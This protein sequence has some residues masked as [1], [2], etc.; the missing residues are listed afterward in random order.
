[1]ESK[2]ARRVWAKIVDDLNARFE[3][4]RTVDKCMHKIKYLIDKYKEKKD[5]NRKIVVILK[6]L[7][8]TMRLTRFSGVVI[9]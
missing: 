9:L 4:N 6:S 5:W 8:S 3:G 7:L 1:M 2:N